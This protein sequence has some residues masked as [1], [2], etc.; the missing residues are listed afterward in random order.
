M[1]NSDDMPPIWDHPALVSTP[2][3]LLRR[4]LTL[5]GVPASPRRQSLARLQLG[6]FD[7]PAPAAARGHPPP[8]RT[9][10]LIEAI[11]QQMPGA[12]VVITDNRTVLLSQSSKAGVRT[13]RVH[14]MFLDAEAPTRAA[15][16]TYLAKGDRKSS[17]VVD[18]FVDAASHLLEMAH[19]PLPE[20]AHQ[21]RVHDLL[22]IFLALN[23]R[24][25]GGAVDA[26][27]GWSQA[28]SPCRRKR[29]SITFGSWDLRAR[30]IVIHPVLDRR[31]VPVECVARVLHHEM[32]HAKVGE[33]RSASGQRIA[34]GRR[35]HK[36]EA[37]FECA[38]DADAW[39]ERHL[40]A[41]LRWRP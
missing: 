3:A 6:L 31:S 22:A 19:K 4:S 11:H 35:F 28:G 13:V 17:A 14:Q 33:E 39:F 21:G 27:L 20:H 37:R 9:R 30:R 7:A 10:A 5:R 36:E 25:F 34:H 1:A 15:V 41:L 32:V 18:A 2:C 26:E 8:S 12:R 16:A 38:R 29:K 24:Y 23:E 40:D